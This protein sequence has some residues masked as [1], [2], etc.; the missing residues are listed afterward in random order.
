MHDGLIDRLRLRAAEVEAD[1]PGFD[2]GAPGQASQAY[3]TVLRVLEMGKVTNQLQR[4]G[5]R[6]LAS[7][8]IM[9]FTNSDNLRIPPLTLEEIADLRTKFIKET[10]RELEDIEET[11]QGEPPEPDTPLEEDL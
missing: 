1:D 2:P 11:E 3:R 5:H 7:W 4:D 9:F 10:E 8:L 6:K